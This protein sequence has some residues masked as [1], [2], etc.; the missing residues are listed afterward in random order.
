MRH[1]RILLAVGLPG[2]YEAILGAFG[3]TFSITAVDNRWDADAAIAADPDILIVEDVL[4]GGRG[5]KI[6]ERGRFRQDGSKRVVMVVGDSDRAALAEAKSKGIIDRWVRKDISPGVFLTRFWELQGA[7]DDVRLAEVVPQATAVVARGRAL[8]QELG[9]G[10]VSTRIRQLLSATASEVV[11]FSDTSTVS[12]FLRELQGH[13]AYTFAHSLRVAILMA[14][15]G[16]HLGLDE[17]HVRLMAETG[18]AHDLGKL[19]IPVD[20]LGKPTRL[21]A[22]EMTVM[23]E[24]PVLGASMLGELYGD[25]ERL[26]AAVRH[27]HEQLSGDGYPDGLKG[28]QIDELSL[29]TAVVDIY[30]ALTDRRDYKAPM[31]MARATA[32]MDELAGPHLEPRLYRRFLEVVQDLDTGVGASP[33]AA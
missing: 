10:V 13:H 33:A 1:Q 16:R 29:L 4:P 11:S 22:D 24:H 8:F 23:R 28:G 31:S 30:T 25:Q 21:T 32:V 14:T 9:T 18:L 17:D 3:D 26:V 5:L 7:Q 27:H 2:R 20:I 19:H 6:C 15:F 12:G